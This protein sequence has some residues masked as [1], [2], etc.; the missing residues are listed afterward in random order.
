MRQALNY[1]FD[2]EEYCRVMYSGAATPATSVLPEIVP[3]YQAQPPYEVD[4]DKAKS[5][6]EEAGYA[7]GF[8]VDI[9]GDN[10]TQE[11][12]GMTFVMQQLENIGVTVN[13]KP[14][15]AATNA[16]LAAAPED[17]TTLH[18]WYV[19]WSQSDADGF[20]RSLLSSA[21]TPPTGYNTAFWKN[22]EFDSELEAGNAAPTEDEQNQHYGTCQDI[23]WPECPWLYLA[24]DNTLLSYKAYL[25]GIKYVPQGIDVIHATLNV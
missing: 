23:V 16:E 19:N 4:L 9:I 1:A 15:E 5:L 7:D 21:M 20:M 8:E 24:S 6:L 12:K 18:M 22:E 17:E 3:G 13:V 14:N 2:Q 25:N 10:S 11:T